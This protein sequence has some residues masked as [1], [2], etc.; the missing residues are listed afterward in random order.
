MTNFSIETLEKCLKRNEFKL[1]QI[2]EQIKKN[3]YPLGS[4]LIYKDRINDLKKSIQ[5]LKINS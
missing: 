2:N 4:Q 5:I 3:V 1:R